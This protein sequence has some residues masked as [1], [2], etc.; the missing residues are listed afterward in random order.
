[1]GDSGN[2]GNGGVP[3]RDRVWRQ[4]SPTVAFERDVALYGASHQILC[5]SS[6]TRKVE[7]VVYINQD[8]ARN[9]RSRGEHSQSSEST[10]SYD[11]AV[12]NCCSIEKHSKSGV[13]V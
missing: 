9:T 2:S 7:G 11:S 1:M 3:T 8:N 4:S 13:S 10:D 5:R 12:I 6:N